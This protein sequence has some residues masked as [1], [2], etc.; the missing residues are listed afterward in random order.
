MGIKS[1]EGKT[2][3]PGVVDR[4]RSPVN[5]PVTLAVACAKG[6]GYPWAPFQKTMPDGSTGD[7]AFLDVT[8][9]DEATGTHRRT[10]T[11]RFD[12]EGEVT[13]R[14][15]PAVE[16]VGYAEFW[17]RLHDDAWCAAHPDHPIA[18]LA[19]A[20]RHFAALQHKLQA[21]EPHPVYGWP[22]GRHVRIRLHAGTHTDPRTGQ[23]VATLDTLTLPLDV[24]QDEVKR[25]AEI[26]RY[27][28]NRRQ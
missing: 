19:A 10:V 1:L 9:K 24:W 13:F 12:H 18:Y 27:L 15:I 25:K 4:D 20:Q 6:A 28:K 17:R 22:L 16:K 3:G 23:Q 8:E 26:A 11:W 2:L 14:P 7:A 21:T 5:S